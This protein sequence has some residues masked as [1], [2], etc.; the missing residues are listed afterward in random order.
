MAPLLKN[1]DL[2][3][4][5][6]FDKKCWQI[7]ELAVKLDYAV[8]SVR[9]LLLQVGYYRSY[10]HNGRWY[11]LKDIP[12]FN[13]FGLWQH[14]KIGFSKRGTLTNTILHIIDSSRSGFPAGALCSMLAT[15]C[16][17]VLTQMYQKGRLDRIKSNA[18]FVYLSADKHSNHRQRITCTASVDKVPLGSISPEAAVR[19]LVEFI[20][21]PSLSSIE[22]SANLK[23]KMN[24]RV[25]P[26]QIK[27][28]FEQHGL[29]KMPLDLKS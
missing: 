25:E 19:V 18:Q 10:T 13:A 2:L 27:A 22:I 8:I 29:K 26:N 21:D 23:N 14:D 28:L 15:D 20:N 3:G 11:T 12:V 16:R 9:R 24:I 1:T 17:A 6:F 7:D 5:L 4:Q